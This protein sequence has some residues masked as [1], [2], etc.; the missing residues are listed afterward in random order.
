MGH[1]TP[2]RSQQ[3]G[4]HIML[5]YNTPKLEK[6]RGKNLVPRTKQRGN[7]METINGKEVV[8][9]AKNA[10]SGRWKT[11]RSPESENTGKAD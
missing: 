9:I 2:T 5:R 11:Q 4:A 7:A 3:H 8:H 6:E 10:L 1:T